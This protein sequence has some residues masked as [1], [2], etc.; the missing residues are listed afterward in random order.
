[1]GSQLSA[2]EVNSRPLCDTTKFLVGI[3]TAASIAVAGCAEEEEGE[4]N[5]GEE[6]D[7]SG[8]VVHDHQLTSDAIGHAVIEGGAT[9][10]LGDEETIWLEATFY[11]KEGTIIDDGIDDRTKT[12]L[13]VSGSSLRFSRR[14]IAPM[15]TTTTSNGAR[16]SE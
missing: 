12:Y 8:V 5:G 7:N 3:G 1:M 2:P 14:L 13:T 4:V 10:E 16:V 9:N 6:G 15:L 11:N